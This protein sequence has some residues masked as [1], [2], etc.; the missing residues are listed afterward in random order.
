MLLF[1]SQDT[2]DATE[3]KGDLTSI[4]NKTG[5][6]MGPFKI[7]NVSPQSSKADIVQNAA[8]ALRERKSTARQIALAQKALLNPVVGKEH[9]FVFC[10][11][12]DPVLDPLRSCPSGA[13]GN[14]PLEYAPPQKDSI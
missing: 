8:I 7:L 3:H 11:D 13:T 14:R 6:D 2:I 5:A 4:A 1:S 12:I 10:L 9:A